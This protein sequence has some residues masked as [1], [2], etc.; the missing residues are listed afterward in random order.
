VVESIGSQARQESLQLLQLEETLGTARNEL[1]TQVRNWKNSLL[2][3]DEPAAF[4]RN[5]ADF[6]THATAVQQA[7]EQARQQALVLGMDSRQIVALQ[8]QHQLTLQ[9]YD[10]AWKV[11]Q[12]GKTSSYKLAEH[13][14][15]GQ[16]RPF[17]VAL[18]KLDKE[19]EQRI[20][21][22]VAGLGHRDDSTLL[23]SR[24]ILFSSVAPSKIREN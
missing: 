20:R 16:Y 9:D 2:R 12:P 22:R 17:L 15:Q 18:D 19:F 24:F 10:E 5:K 13:M 7:F 14:T 1:H 23:T 4:A 11:L 6:Y 21:E 3:S 8:A